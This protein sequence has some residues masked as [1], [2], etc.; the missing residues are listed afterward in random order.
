MCTFCF[1]HTARICS[2]TDRSIRSLYYCSWLIAFRVVVHSQFT[3]ADECAAL[4]RF[5]HVRDLVVPIG[6]M[7]TE[8]NSHLVIYLPVFANKLVCLRNHSWRHSDGGSGENWLWGGWMADTVDDAEVMQFKSNV[9]CLVWASVSLSC[10][11][12]A[13]IIKFLWFAVFGRLWFAVFCRRW[14]WWSQDGLRGDLVAVRW[15]TQKFFFSKMATTHQRGRTVGSTE[16]IVKWFFAVN[17]RD[18]NICYRT[19]SSADLPIDQQQVLWPSFPNENH[20][21]EA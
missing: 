1:L 19:S 2:E 16:D 3:N 6:D 10:L 20:D 15:V 7:S 14:C 18:Q 9:P 11:T 21:F 17:L 12:L 8:L 13:C 4:I 5:V